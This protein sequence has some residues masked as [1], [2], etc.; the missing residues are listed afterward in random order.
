MP[1]RGRGVDRR[2]GVDGDGDARAP[3]SASARSRSGSTDLV[4]EQQV[5]A[6]AGAREAEQLAWRR[7][8]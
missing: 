5:V 2:V 4:R 6:E 3:Q 7:A 8:R 1:L